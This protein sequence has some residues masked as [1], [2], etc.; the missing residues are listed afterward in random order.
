MRPNGVAEYICMSPAES[1]AASHAIR[2]ASLPSE[3]A[4]SMRKAGGRRRGG[5]STGSVMC[6]GGS[7]RPGASSRGGSGDATS[8]ARQRP[9]TRLMQQLRLCTAPGGACSTSPALESFTTQRS[10]HRGSCSNSDNFEWP[11]AVSLNSKPKRVRKS[12]FKFDNGIDCCGPPASRS[13]CRCSRSVSHV[14]IDISLVPWH[15]LWHWA[16]LSFNIDCEW[17]YGTK[18]PSE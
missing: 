17:T 18:D 1:H 14:A 11:R 4:S 16:F 8:S 15:G 3:P 13:C 7:A 9:S 10:R 2:S 6:R 5:A 12:R